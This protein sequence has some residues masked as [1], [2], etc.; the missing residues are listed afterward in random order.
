MNRHGPP[1]LRIA[2]DLDRVVRVAVHVREDVA[3]RVGADGDEPEVEGPPQ[4]ADLSKL[5]RHGQ[6]RVLGPVVVGARGHLRH[7]AVARVAAEPDGL[8]RFGRR[9]RRRHGPGAP[10]RAHL[11]QDAAA[12]AV[13]ARQAGEAG[14]NGL[15]RRRGRRGS[16]NGSSTLGLLVRVR[17]GGLGS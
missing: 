13:L 10:E 4:R 12:G 17:L 16:S 7:R 15:G 9:A 1:A 5:R 6:V 8:G 3:G 11:V 14:G 2:E